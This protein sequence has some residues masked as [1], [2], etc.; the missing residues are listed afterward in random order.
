MNGD[1]YN[2]YLLATPTGRT[3]IGSTFELAR[4][5]RQHNGEI[6]GGAWRT[7]RAAGSWRRVCHVAGFT[8]RKEALQF[9][10]A[11][12]HPTRSKVWRTLIKQCGFTV[13]KRLLQ[14]HTVLSAVDAYKHLHLVEDG[15]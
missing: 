2:V 7:K 15:A 4:R 5:L 13:T 14:A 12:Q 10:W 1:A 6:K 11:W 8:S 9:E 3:Y